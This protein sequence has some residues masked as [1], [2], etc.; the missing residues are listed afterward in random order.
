MLSHTVHT[1]QVPADHL[2]YQKQ[3]IIKMGRKISGNLNFGSTRL[4][5]IGPFRWHLYYLPTELPCDVVFFQEAL[6]VRFKR[7]HIRD[8]VAFRV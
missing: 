4:V 1:M 6:V 7:G 5:A 2:T 3:M 8:L